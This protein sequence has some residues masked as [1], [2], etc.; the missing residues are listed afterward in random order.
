MGALAS[1]Q[2]NTRRY[3]YENNKESPLCATSPSLAWSRRCSHSKQAQ[4]LHR[5]GKL[6]E[7]Q[8]NALFRRAPCP[9]LS[10]LT[11]DVRKHERLFSG[12]NLN[13]DAYLFWAALLDGGGHLVREEN[14]VDLVQIL[15]G[16]SRMFD[17]SFPTNDTKQQCFRENPAQM[18]DDH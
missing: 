15:S 16:H 14:L 13:L 2:A 5:G 17:I 6:A 7:A 1:Q 11:S 10:L 4:G 9:L 8:E 3:A 12:D 18:N